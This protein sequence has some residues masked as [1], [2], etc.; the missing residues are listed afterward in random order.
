ML[1]TRTFLFGL[2]V[3]LL[4]APVYA[5]TSRVTLS[6]NTT[7]GSDL[8]RIEDEPS[9]VINGFDLTPLPIQIPALIE[10][11]S[12]DIFEPVPLQT[13]EVVVYQ[14]Q[15]GGSPADATLVGAYQTA[16]RQSGVFTAQFPE[17][18]VVTAPVVWVG[19][20][21]PVGTEFRA[22]TQGSS[23]LTYWAWT[24]GQ[25]F[26]LRDLSSAAILGPSDGTDPVNLDIGGVARITAVART[27]NADVDPNLLNAPGTVQ[28]PQEAVEYLTNYNGCPGVFYD[29]GDVNI[30]LGSSVQPTCR[31]VEAWNSPNAP[32][33]YSRF[34]VDFFTL[35]DLT[36]FTDQGTVLS[37]G[38]S[39]AVTHCIAPPL[40]VRDEVVLGIAY[41]SPRRWDLLETVVFGNL[42]C[43]EVTRG[44]NLAYFVPN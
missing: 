44:G 12:I 16:I 24:P 37:E 3:L 2:I 22:D 21:L 5:Q 31:Q 23:I 6:N 27:A 14:D 34:G 17:P 1:R 28:N 40:D 15:N 10:S 35:W 42:A 36:F 25:R 33:G 20:Y 11:V 29:T 43:A 30:S 38:V 13:V 39:I 7:L 41:G 4:T 32:A 9:L 19:F 18:V 8:W 26:N